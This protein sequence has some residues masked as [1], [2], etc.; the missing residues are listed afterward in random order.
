MSERKSTPRAPQSL[1][2]S[3]QQS[4]ANRNAM[5]QKFGFIPL[6]ILQ[7]GRGA[8]HKAMFHYAGDA[9]VAANM[10]NN[11][12]E[13]QQRL[14][15]AGYAKAASSPSER[16]AGRGKPG[17]SIMPAELVEFF[18]KYYAHPQQVYLDPF[19]GQ[20]IQMQVAKRYK[21]HYYGYDI[22]QEFFK[23]IASVRDIIDDQ[24]TTLSIT[25]ADS[26]YPTAIPDDIGDFSFHSPPY[27]D[28]EFYGVESGQLGYQQ[29]YPAFLEN[30]HD[31]AK[32]WLPKF[33]RGAYQIVNV[34][35]F[36]KHGKF[37]A[38]HADTIA[39]FERAGWLLT[40]IWIVN[41]LVGGIS[42]AFAVDFNSQRI[43]PKVHEYCLCFRKP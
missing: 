41:G 40:D 4:A 24:Q 33:K 11:N 8:L 30:M 12:A 7:I 10:K 26:R 35:D 25:C 17:L 43:A 13:K 21:L 18:I 37:Y 28:I 32:A 5:Q 38:Y 9:S 19:M 2:D 36:R 23:Y 20:G 3:L 22:S 31:V 42:K 29:S 39:L 1:R 27:W 16:G 6:S 15:E 14:A 34:N